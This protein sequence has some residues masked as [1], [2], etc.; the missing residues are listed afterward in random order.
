MPFAEIRINEAIEIARLERL[1]Q[2]FHK[3]KEKLM[4]DLTRIAADVAAQNAAVQ[5]AV[6]AIKANVADPTVQAQLD[7]L[8]V[9]IEANTKALTDA[10]APP[11]PAAAPVAAA[12]A[13]ASATPAS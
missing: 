12:P 13:A 1:E 11:A 8:A 6:A 7:Q 3:L 5:G 10:L 2:Q 9:A 4:T